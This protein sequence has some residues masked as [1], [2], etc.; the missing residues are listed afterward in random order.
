MRSSGPTAVLGP[1]RGSGPIAALG[2][3]PDAE[4][5]YR[6]QA[7]GT[8]FTTY[9]A[10][11]VHGNPILQQQR[12][13]NKQLELAGKARHGA[14]SGGVGKPPAYPSPA[15]Q[16][17]PPRQD[18]VASQGV[19]EASSTSA[20]PLRSAI[21][22][23]AEAPMD[24]DE[25]A[26]PAPAAPQAASSITPIA[27]D[28]PEEHRGPVVLAAPP[29][30]QSPSDA[31]PTAR[32]SNIDGGAALSVI[33]EDVAMA[34]VSNVP[35]GA[36]KRR[37]R[38]A[39]GENLH[40]SPQSG[41]GA[42]GTAPPRKCPR[43][44]DASASGKQT[45]AADNAAT[46]RAH[47]G[48]AP[49]PINGASTTTP[50]L[51]PDISFSHES[52]HGSQAP[53]EPLSRS[54]SS[55]ASQS[56]ASTE[57]SRTATPSFAPI[58]AEEVRSAPAPGAVDKGKGKAPARTKVS[59]GQQRNSSVP[60]NRGVE[61]HSPVPGTRPV[62]QT[63]SDRFRARPWPVVPDVD[64][65]ID[66]EGA[67]D[68]LSAV[69]RITYPQGGPP[70]MSTLNLSGDIFLANHV[71]R[72]LCHEMR[73]TINHHRDWLLGRYEPEHV[74]PRH[75]EIMQALREL[76]DVV[77]SGSSAHVSATTATREARPGAAATTL[78]PSL[79]PSGVPPVQG[80]GHQRGAFVSPIAASSLGAEVASQSSSSGLSESGLREIL[81]SSLAPFHDMAGNVQDLTRRFAELEPIT[82]RVNDMSMHMDT[83]TGQVEILGTDMRSLVAR[84]KRLEDV[85]P[86][87]RN[88]RAVS[89]YQDRVGEAPA[90]M[91]VLRDGLSGSAARVCGPANIIAPPVVTPSR[92]LNEVA[93]AASPT[94]A[95]RAPSIQRRTSNQAPTLPTSPAPATSRH[96]TP[97]AHAATAGDRDTP[98]RPPEQP[99]AEA[100]TPRPSVSPGARAVVAVDTVTSQAHK[101]PELDSPL[102]T[103][104]SSGNVS[105]ANSDRGVD[106]P[107]SQAPAATSPHPSGNA[108]D[109]EEGSSDEDVPLETGEDWALT[110]SAQRRA[111]DREGSAPHRVSQTHV[112]EMSSGDEDA[113][114]SSDDEQPAPGPA[115]ASP[116]KGGRT[117]RGRGAGSRPPPADAAA[118]RRFGLRNRQARS[119]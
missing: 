93:T 36:R 111:A 79:A 110:Q 81:A 97:Q 117:G 85:G 10:T 58:P 68:T 87:A 4:P 76:K 105:A 22:A 32:S 52:E 12:Q 6:G 2:P 28:G 54:L 55:Q 41:D 51:V 56:G 17:S 63:G 90:A 102:T 19:A 112:G 98:P 20:P 101:T 82:G 43:R 37:R 42:S 59:G 34:D 116:Q 5:S 47:A 8:S 109:V 25:D 70:P 99:P 16:Y 119:G 113:D 69:G 31:R 77:A 64:M 40:P 39:A 61:F 44:Q 45:A 94:A 14:G 15:P 50:S 33:Q 3:M 107:P 49:P 53:S 86:L 9:K 29:S 84:V 48:D 95:S 114:G 26:P 104:P 108:T 91:L 30:N 100:S 75:R 118:G 35:E 1:M 71:E 89:E 57:V 80:G 74:A 21:P 83:M 65:R 92:E 73:D 66:G 7:R 60:R 115:T 62:P 11:T 23:I 38:S 27:T 13:N 46:G 103:N 18:A 67:R 96:D 88:L 106:A 24:L 72:A 78:H